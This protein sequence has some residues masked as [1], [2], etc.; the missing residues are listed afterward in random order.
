MKRDS[1]YG[2]TS[3]RSIVVI[4]IFAMLALGQYSM[5][6]AV[7]KGKGIRPKTSLSVVDSKGKLVGTVIQRDSDE[8]YNPLVAFEVSDYVFLLKVRGDR[9]STPGGG[10]EGFGP[11]FTSTNCSGT[12]FAELPYLHTPQSGAASLWD[13]AVVGSPGMSVYVAPFGTLPQRIT[14]RSWLPTDDRCE[15]FVKTGEFFP[16]QVLVNFST[17]FTPPFTVR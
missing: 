3:L 10:G 15:P 17:I 4:I 9:V 16:V 1:R 14:V 6:L 12:P 7:A 5:G 13:A 11:L 8:L 2:V